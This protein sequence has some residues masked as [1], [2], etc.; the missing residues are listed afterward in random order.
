VKRKSRG[1]SGFRGDGEWRQPSGGEE[2]YSEEVLLIPI[3]RSIFRRKI[4]G[5]RYLEITKSLIVMYV[6]AGLKERYGIPQIL[7]S[8]NNTYAAFTA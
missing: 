6:Y 7:Q 2:M 5:S 1:G 4:S 3:E 8:P